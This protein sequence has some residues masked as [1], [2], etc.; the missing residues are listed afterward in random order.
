MQFNIKVALV[1]LQIE[2]N[3]IINYYKYNSDTVLKI[4]R[5][6]ILCSIKNY[7]KFNMMLNKIYKS[8][9]IKFEDH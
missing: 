5:N 4:S 7:T 6:A 1:L 3:I 9:I 2:Y 8:Q